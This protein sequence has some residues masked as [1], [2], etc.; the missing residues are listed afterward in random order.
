M[1]KLDKHTAEE[2]TRLVTQALD[3]NNKDKFRELFLELHPTDQVELYSKFSETQQVQV[4]NYITAEEFAEVFQGMEIDQ[5]KELVKRLDHAYAT[6]LFNNMY[7]DDLA[8]FIGE[9]EDKEAKEVIGLLDKEEAEDIKEILNYEDETAGAIMTTE[10]ISIVSSDTVGNVMESLREKQ[11]DA[12]T[13]YY[14]Y[15]VNDL[16]QLVGVLSLRD[17][18]FSKLDEKIENIMSTRVVSVN[19]NTDQEE[20]AKM[21]KKYDLLAIPVVKDDGEFIGIVTVD[22]VM[23]VLEEEATEDIGEI[24]ATRG[25]VDAN[26]TSVK[27]ARMRAPWILLLMFLGLITANVIGQFEETL[28][29]VILLAVFIPLIMDSA[30]NTGTQALAVVVRGMALGTLEKGGVKQLLKREFGTGIMLGLMCAI[31]LMIIVPFLYDSYVLAFI[32]GFSLFI[33]LSVATMVGAI[34]PIIINKLKIDPAVASGPFITTI[35]DIIG[36]LIYFSVA[37]A[38]I[39]YLPQV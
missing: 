30:G 19:V 14:L 3:A 15:V 22:D 35:N 37:T 10:F 20:V 2:Y 7:S 29:T 34:V 31:A 38:L 39:N 33:T 21:I 4:H 28:E 16:H 9:L 6:E 17:L 12:E 26:I 8:S 24:T 32:V 36:L 18:M 27:A 5:Q 23:D 11:R 13:I 25:S 1:V